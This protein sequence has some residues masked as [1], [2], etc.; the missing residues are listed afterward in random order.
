MFGAHCVCRS[1]LSLTI[2]FYSVVLLMCRLRLK[3]K[4]AI[5]SSIFMRTFTHS[6]QK[7]ACLLVKFQNTKPFIKAM[8]LDQANTVFII[9]FVVSLYSGGYQMFLI[10][11]QSV[12]LYKSNLVVSTSGLLTRIGGDMGF[13]KEILWIIF[14]IF[15]GFEI[16]KSFCKKTF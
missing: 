13:C 1:R 12:D 5:Y 7:L 9:T 11:D 6:S 14:I 8:T 4:L 16:A 3:R 15:S 2:S 10:F